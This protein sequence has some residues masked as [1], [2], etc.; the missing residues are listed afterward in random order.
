MVKLI[1]LL[2][3]AFMLT[4]CDD[5]KVTDSS[6]IVS[7]TRI[8]G[9]Q[10]HFDL[11]KLMYYEGSSFSPIFPC[12]LSGFIRCYMIS[13]T[14]LAIPDESILPGPLKKYVTGTIEELS[15]EYEITRSVLSF[16]KEQYDGYFI[17]IGG[18][19][20]IEPDDNYYGAYFYS[21]EYGIIVFEI[22]HYS[23]RDI[24]LGDTNMYLSSPSL[25]SINGFK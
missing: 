7:Y 6:N 20:P 11:E 3:I 10:V 21:V 14:V 9:G 16:G 19:P 12:Q 25:W 22:N 23:P 24:M 2:S 17:N 4:A 13:S 1:A 18:S 15:S 8:D 5:F